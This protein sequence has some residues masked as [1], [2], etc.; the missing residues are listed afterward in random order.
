MTVLDKDLC[1]LPV[2]SVW[3]SQLR[4]RIH[5]GTTVVLAEKPKPQSLLRPSVTERAA[6]HIAS[7]SPT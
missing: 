3:T 4:T 6:L 2:E 1:C 5:L 7:S